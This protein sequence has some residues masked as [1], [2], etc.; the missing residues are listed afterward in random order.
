ME[1]LTIELEIKEGNTE[2][3]IGKTKQKIEDFVRDV[4]KKQPNIRFTVSDKSFID[5]D[6]LEK[7]AEMTRTSFANIAKVRLDNGQIGLLTK[8][9]VVAAERSKQLSHDISSIKTELANPNRKSSI[10][11]LTEELRAAEV[12]ADSLNR[13]LNSLGAGGVSG[14]ASG[15]RASGGAAS[16]RLSSFQK[17]NLSYQINDVLTGLASGQNVTQIAAQQ[18]GQI[19]QIFNPAQ[20]TAF[21]AAYGSL[22]TILGA[23][24]V[25]IAATWKITGDIRKEAERRLKVE[26]MIAGAMNRQILSSKQAFE[27]YKKF[28]EETA[29]DRRFSAFLEDGS[30]DDLKNR[31]ASLERIQN[32]NLST[33]TSTLPVLENGKVV[34]KPNEEFERRKQEITALDAQIEALQKKSASSNSVF[35]Q[36]FGLIQKEQ[37]AALRLEEK[38][39]E[40]EKKRIADIEKAREKVKE[41][42]KAYL[43]VFDSLYQKTGAN[44]PFVVV[45]SE[46]DK[47]LQ[48]MRESLRGLPP[49]LQAVA[50]QMQQK[51]SANALFG[52]RLDNNLGI[53]DLR[54]DAAN[55]RN[56]F[57]SK[58][59]TR[60]QQ[61]YIA[62]FL[63]N[64]PNY[65]NLN[66]GKSEDFIKQDILSRGEYS[67]AFDTPER[68]LNKSLEEQYK[69]I[70][71]R[72]FQNEDQKA[73]ADR[74]FIA[75]T[76]GVN[77]LDLNSGLREKAA[78]IRESE[79]IRRENF[80]KENLS[81]QKEKLAV[82]KQVAE[83]TKKLIELA[84]SGGKEAV[85]II[86]KNETNGAASAVI[87]SPTA[88]DTDAQKGRFFH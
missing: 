26:E 5:L 61:K 67:G 6:K 37:E 74:K 27:D 66:H 35:N 15:G 7:R 12:E 39:I 8:E 21:A 16:N 58:K 54:Q 55:F 84:K 51:L 4:E 47:A 63:R 56:P 50:V 1:N 45:F 53:L 40:A 23:G 57:D 79:A 3:V 86:L 62:D 25:A 72:G 41:L 31:R 9:I 28:R 44:N 77:P 88:A 83:N 2:V 71:G 46:G 76:S 19:A 32:L 20:I 64:N 10:K 78:Q 48:M 70:Y 87:S 11:F 17:Q 29:K 33:N 36:S 68:R 13:K 43:S 60:D 69:L 85:E 18:S 65:L 30:V 73:A 22:V 59:Q 82:E 14:G 34:Q 38:R 52:A 24:A 49:E 81:I 75:L 42:E 80:E